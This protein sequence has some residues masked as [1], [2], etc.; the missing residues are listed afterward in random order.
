MTV[1]EQQRRDLTIAGA[2][3]GVLLACALSGWSDP[4]LLLAPAAALLIPLLLGRYP[5]EQLI[6]RAAA[7]VRSAPRRAPRRGAPR[8]RPGRRT[9]PRGSALMGRALAAHAPPLAD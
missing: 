1:A 8:L 3:A 5:G 9:T 2:L 7:A 6:V 4:L